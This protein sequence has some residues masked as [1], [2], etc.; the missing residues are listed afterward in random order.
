MGKFT[1]KGQ[2]IGGDS[3]L[4]KLNYPPF[5]RDFERLFGVKPCDIID[6]RLL[7]LQH[8]Y[9]DIAKL[10]AICLKAG[11][12]VDESLGEFFERKGGKEFARYIGRH[13]FGVYSATEEVEQ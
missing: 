6:N 9:F 2:A 1:Y 5:V 4:H 10:S 3:D 12:A 7:G 8:L 13:F 11:M